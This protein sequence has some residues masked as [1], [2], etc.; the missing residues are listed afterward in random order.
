MKVS[1]TAISLNVADPQVSADFL[2]RHVGHTVAME[3]DGFVSLSHPDGGPNIVYLRTGLPSFKPA[4]RAGAAGDGLLLAFVV[5]DVDAAYRALHAA[6]AE[7]GPHA[8]LTRGLVG[9][10]DAG[11]GAPGALV[12]NLPGST[13]GVRDGLAVLLP[14][15]PHVLD[16]LTGGDH[17]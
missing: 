7:A 1:A 4:H 10:V 17:A 14:L 11:P 13:G 3:A 2:C 6:G 12:A 5:D 8:L 16:Q 15:V 9:V